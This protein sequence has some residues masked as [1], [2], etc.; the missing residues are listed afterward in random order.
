MKFSL[1]KFKS[2]LK[3]SGEHSFQN[4]EHIAK[5]FRNLNWTLKWIL[6]F[7]PSEHACLSKPSPFEL[8][9]LRG[10]N[11]NYLSIPSISRAS[12][13][14]IAFSSIFI[15][16]IYIITITCISGVF[17]FVV[18]KCLNWIGTDNLRSEKVQFYE[19]IHKTVHIP[20]G[21][22]SKIIVNTFTIKGS[23]VTGTKKSMGH[24][25]HL[26]HLVHT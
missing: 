22:L 5:I 26:S 4:G 12:A 24:N 13:I 17:R 8:I 14:T 9:V 21:F 2:V 19:F 10:I 23:E 15:S 18:F 20:W 3:V 6:F 11:S 16:E 7:H 25:T 1:S